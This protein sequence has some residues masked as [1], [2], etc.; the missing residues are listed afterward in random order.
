MKKKILFVNDEMTM[1][2]V[3]RILNTLL[4]QID[5][6]KYEIDVLILHKR[7]ELL[8]EIPAGINVIGGTDFFD[9]ID[10]PLLNCDLSNI[11]SKLELLFYMKTGLIRNR[12][13]K[14]RKKI[15]SKQY[16]VEF[17]AKEGF[18]TLFTA[19]GDSKKKINWIQ[20]D[21][22]E[23]NYSANHMRL[24]KSALKN[25]DMNIACSKTVMES[26]KGIFDVERICVIH[27]LMDDKRIFNLS[28]EKASIVADKD[29]INL[30][31]VARFH[32][33]KGVDRLIRAY[34][35]LKDYYSLTIIGDGELREELYSLSK[36]LK[37]YDGI[38]WLGMRTNP[39]CDI[40]QCDLL[41]LPSLYEG[42]PTITVESLISGTPVL[43]LDVAGV[44]EQIVE[45]EY[46]WVIDNSQEALIDKMAELKKCK[47]LLTD[48][49]VKLQSYKYDNQSILN[50][51]Y[52]LFEKE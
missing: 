8:E 24:I 13:I 45:E 6:E 34:A 4:N 44:K 18:C 1:G 51:Y 12:I 10:I 36:E 40:R 29:K 21:Y 25:I 26:Y 27:N 7:G 2:G 52:D 39:Y 19:C 41:V 37:V 48:Y 33:Q 47:Q 3:A 22:K 35:K 16:D 14:E 28:N 46:G 23:K 20:V 50:K 11:F 9:T 31:C 30:I 5:R 17:S 32:P 49:K 42:Y 15:L 38:K 43:A